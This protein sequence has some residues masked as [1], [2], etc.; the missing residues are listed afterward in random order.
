MEQLGSVGRKRIPI[1]RRFLTTVLLTTII[2]IL[3]VS[4]TG[5]F[6]IRWARTA[7]ETALTEQLETSLKSTMQARVDTVNAKLEHCEKYIELSLDFI[8]DMYANRPEMLARGRMFYAPRDTTDYELTRAVAKA[9]L[10][11]DNLRDDLLFFSNLET[12]WKPIATENEELIS[13]VYLGTKD[14]LLVSYDRYSYLSCPPEGHELVYNYFVSEWYKRGMAEDDIFYTGVYMDSQGRG[15]TIT[16]ASGFNNAAGERAG[17]IGMDFDLTALYDE[18]FP[19]DIGNG[20]FSFAFDHEGSLI[21][22]DSDMVDLRDYT[23]LTLDELDK[24]R[25]DSD[26][27]LEIGDSIYV[28]IS[29]DRVGWTLCTCVPKDAVQEGIREADISMRNAFL[30]FVAIVLAILVIAV[31]A[32]NRAIASVTHPLELL[33]H[34][35]KTIAEGDLSHRAQ[36]YRNDEIGDITSGMNA[37]V[38]RLNF[39]LNELTSSQQHADAMSRLATRDALTGIRNK[40]AFNEQTK[41]LAE[42]LAEG[43]GKFGFALLD[44]NNLK[45]INDTY[46]HEKG[47]IAIVRLSRIV[48]QVFEHSPVFRVGGDEFV[49]VLTGKELENAETLV[50]A[51]KDTIREISEDASGQ[52]WERGSAAIGYARYVDKLDSGT[53]SVL[54]RADKAMYD[55][56]K[57]MKGARR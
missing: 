53:E 29:L 50:Q 14:G 18:L 40:T 26:G 55:N 52:P 56:K 35:I 20:A 19:T 11:E 36:V 38:D 6:C 17:V 31:V 8:A 23:G 9:A 5:F 49:V 21:S 33:G 41:I 25:T 3:V 39:T 22:T 51:F 48:C 46:G 45:L 2:S 28:S 37:M 16:T 7:T 32:V 54:A 30:V 27:I 15:L 13:T 10:T 34:D 43:E 57:S 12:I 4:V 1:R 47:D 44:L 42:E 24:L